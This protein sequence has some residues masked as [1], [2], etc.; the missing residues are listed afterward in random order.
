MI[1]CSCHGITDKEYLE[2]LEKKGK[3]TAAPGRA[4]L[5][6]SCCGCCVPTLQALS[7]HSGARSKTANET[8]RTGTSPDEESGL[9][10]S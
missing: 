3:S 5:A 6:G 10:G 7:Q 9:S 8:Q 4:C 2:H 1:I